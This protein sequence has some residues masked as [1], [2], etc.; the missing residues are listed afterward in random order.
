MEFV[1]QLLV[2]RKEDEIDDSVMTQKLYPNLPTVAP[3]TLKPK[4]TRFWTRK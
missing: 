2:T 4:I 3:S 1:G